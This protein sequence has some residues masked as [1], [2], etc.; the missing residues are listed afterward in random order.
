MDDLLKRRVEAAAAAGLAAAA[1]AG[2]APG[3]VRAAG[4]GAGLLSVYHPLRLAVREHRARETKPFRE[5]SRQA[6]VAAYLA[7]SAELQAEPLSLGL[8][9]YVVQHQLAPPFAPY[10]GPVARFRLGPR[11]PSS[12][13]VWRR[14]VGVIGTAW[15]RAQPVGMDLGGLRDAAGTARGW[16]SLSD[17]DRLGLTWDEFDFLAAHYGSVVAVPIAA[18]RDPSLTVG[19]VALDATPGVA[20]N[21]LATPEV[22]AVL[23]ETATVLAE[24]LAAAPATTY[25]GPGALPALAVVARALLDRQPTR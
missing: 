10:L 13:I 6:L 7:I 22:L 12:R 16:R 11:P 23:G 25:P 5:R 14:G 19:C 2:R 17:A 9:A 8:H 4:A 15:R 1:A 21:D 3:L 20:L 18:V 24:E